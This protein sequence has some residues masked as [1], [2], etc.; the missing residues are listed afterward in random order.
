[1][2]TIKDHDS[3]KNV[4]LH[5]YYLGKDIEKKKEALALFNYN[6]RPC[7]NFEI[8]TA[9]NPK[10]NKPTISLYLELDSPYID[11]Q[12]RKVYYFSNEVLFGTSSDIS[13]ISTYSTITDGKYGVWSPYLPF[14]DTKGAPFYNE[15]NGSSIE[16]KPAIV[17]YLKKH[18]SGTEEQVFDT[19]VRWVVSGYTIDRDHLYAAIAHND[20]AFD[21]YYDLLTDFKFGTQQQEDKETRDIRLMTAYPYRLIAYQNTCFVNLIY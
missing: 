17:D 15:Y 7:R 8:V 14:F 5:D 16:H 10:F 9:T 12:N 19:F 11:V 2:R 1:M 18:N 21:K 13:M 6:I 20:Q 4:L 3:V